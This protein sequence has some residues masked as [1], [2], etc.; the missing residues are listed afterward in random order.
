MFFYEDKVEEG[1]LV[2]SARLLAKVNQRSRHHYHNHSHLTSPL[3][4]NVDAGSLSLFALG[5]VIISAVEKRHERLTL[6]G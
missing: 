5:Q 3:T 6:P 1:L 4:E 2:T